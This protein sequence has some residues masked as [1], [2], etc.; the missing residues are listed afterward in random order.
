M[1][2]L[3]LDPDQEL[4]DALIVLPPQPATDNCRLTTDNYLPGDNADDACG[5]VDLSQARTLA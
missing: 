4:L 2:T 1:T 3:D 5:D